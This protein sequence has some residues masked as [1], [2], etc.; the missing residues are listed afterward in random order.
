M[1]NRFPAWLAAV[2]S[3]IAPSAASSQTAPP[4]GSTPPAQQEAIVLSP[5][6]VSSELDRG[7]SAQNTLA[8][9]RVSTE[10]KDIPAAISVFNEQFLNDIA[11]ADLLQAIEYGMGTR[12]DLD[13]GRSGGPIGEGF[14]NGDPDIR[15]RG[16]PGG[17]RTRNYFSN[18]G[19]IDTYNKG[20]LE[21]SRGPNSILNG[22]GSPAGVINASTKQADVNRTFTTLSVRVGQWD[23]QRYTAD[24][25]VPLIKQKLGVRLNYLHQ[26]SE[27]WRDHGHNDSDAV[28]LASTWK[29]DPKTTLRIEGEISERQVFTPR[30]WIANEQL[31]GWIAAGRPTYDPFVGAAQPGSPT[32][33]FGSFPGIRNRGVRTVFIHNEGAAY[34]WTNLGRGDTLPP[35]QTRNSFDFDLYHRP[36]TVLEGG[37]LGGERSYRQYGASIERQLIRNMYLEVAFDVQSMKSLAYNAGD[38]AGFGLDGDPSEFLPNGQ[39]NPHAGQFYFEQT[40]R[41]DISEDVQKSLRATLSYEKDLGRWGRHRLAALAERRDAVAKYTI[42]REVWVDVT[43]PNNPRPGFNQV[44]FESGQNQ[45]HRRIYFTDA[46]I[47]SMQG[48]N[49]ISPL[50]QPIGLVNVIDPVVGDPNRSRQ[51]ETRLITAQNNRDDRNVTEAA[52]FVMQNHW[53]DDH[54]VT[55]FGYREE[56]LTRTGST[57]VRDAQGFLVPFGQRNA[58]SDPTVNGTTRNY[59]IVARPPLRSLEWL[60]V[61]YNHATSASVGGAMLVFGPGGG[62]PPPPPSGETD[63]YGVKLDLFKGKVFLTVAN[64]KTSAKN[65]AAGYSSLAN[66]FEAPL[67]AAIDAGIVT[68][69]NFDAG[70]DGVLSSNDVLG[71][72]SDTFDSTS[73]G[74]EGELFYNPNRN[75]RMTLNYTRQETTRVNLTPRLRAVVESFKPL[76]LQG[77]NARLLV[78]QNGNTAG[79]ER[80]TGLFDPNDEGQNVAERLRAAELDYLQQITV[81]EGKAPNGHTKHRLNMFA[82]YTFT[83][84]PLKNVSIGGGVRYRSG[85]AAGFTTGTLDI[86][87]DLAVATSANAGIDPAQFSKEFVTDDEL[88]F[89]LKIGYERRLTFR[90]RTIPWSIQLN[91]RNLTNQDDYRLTQVFLDGVPRQY[92]LGTPRQMFVTNTFKF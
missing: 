87:S 49:W 30:P 48:V 28:H 59:G 13:E 3:L 43:D 84:G 78:P 70:R 76:L 44:N 53:L 72:E 36:E 69:A 57:A 74:W 22:F 77:D 26:E 34:D 8:G 42:A 31:S 91:V 2:A 63:D 90:G 66:A 24:F 46:Q 75:F 60:S 64:Y 79:I 61:F 15:I 71:G 65:D 40:L 32:T 19:E 56:T 45:V 23:E 89:D 14:N 51:L 7:Y 62:V 82:N 54:I 38:A 73:E 5:F 9:S 37:G 88:F 39:P 10:L 41:S 35:N 33:A 27:H 81:F 29:I 50:S 55:F 68:T 92:R 12:P 85:T 67:Q 1:K 17:R 11:A 58:E 6:E 21:F 25:N 80:T 52:L 83:E 86:P 4:P 18:L 20:R 16:L 47:A